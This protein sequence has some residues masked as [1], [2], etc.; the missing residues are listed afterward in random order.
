MLDGKVVAVAGA[1]GALGRAVCAACLA[2]GARVAGAARR[3]EELRRLAASLAPAPD[4]FLPCAA[5]AG[6]AAGAERLVAAASDAYGRVDALVNAAGAW[7]G[8]RPTWE[9]DPAAYQRLLATNLGT[10]F[11][12]ARAA[13]P[14]ML[15]QGGGAVVG[16]ASVAA[17]GGQAGSAAYAASKAGLLALLASL[18]LEVRGRGVRVNAIVPDVIDT[19]SNRRAM[20]GGDFS[21][22][23]KPEH[24][25]RVVVFL[26]SDLGQAIH[27]AQIPVSAG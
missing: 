1:T 4:R 19:E 27:G 16:V 3:D 11:H 9:T 17:H 20:P 12:L 2:A 8:G 13:L 6:E 25:A 21:R 15:A 10:M 22:W 14:R 7:E 23:V 26:C 24:V 18:A 5:D